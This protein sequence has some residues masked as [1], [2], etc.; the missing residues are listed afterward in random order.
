[1]K[2]N[3]ILQIIILEALTEISEGAIFKTLLYLIEGTPA[4][5]FD[6]SNSS[7]EKRR[8]KSS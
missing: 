4:Q 3:F 8:K 5:C 7:Q 1:M 6:I 2:V